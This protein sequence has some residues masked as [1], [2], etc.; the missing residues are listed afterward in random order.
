VTR[1]RRR[2]WLLAAAVASFVGVAGSLLLAPPVSAHAGLVSSVPAASS[3]L[4]EAP[5]S[6]VLDFDE[7]LEIDLAS[8]ELFD[9][10]AR[11]IPLGTVGG[12]DGDD[13]IVSA[14][15]PDL[16][17]GIFAVVWRV[18]SV[19]GHVV[20]GSFS[21]TV[22]RAD[23]N[24]GD[25]L[26]QLAT[27]SG[28]D[29]AVSRLAL[30]FRLVGFVGLVVFVGGGL[31][32][33][34]TARPPAATSTVLAGGWTALLVGS[35]GVFGTHA[36]A[37]TAGGAGDVFAPSAWSAVAGTDTGRAMLVRVSLV[38]ALGA[39]VWVG[40]TVER[41]STAWWR[42]LVGL[43]AVGV[44][45]T[46][47]AAGHAA[48]TSPRAL[49][50]LVDAVHLA[51]IAVWL[52][53]LALFTLG[54]RDWLRDDLYEPVVRRF[55]RMAGVAVPVVVVTGIAQTRELAGGFG[56][57][58]D[59][60]WGRGMLVKLSIVVVLVTVGGV[61]RW[62]LHHDGPAGLRRT[63]ALEAVLG[64]A[65]L[66]TVAFIVAEPP[67]PV[68]QGK[69]FS[70][71]LAQAG[72]IVDITVTPGK[73]GA[74]EIHLVIT[75]PGGN[76]RPVTNA[77]ARMALPERDVPITPVTM[78]AESANHYSGRITLPFGGD[79]KL[80]VLVEDRPGSTILFTTT[81]SI[82]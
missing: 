6:I 72:I 32:A 48:A 7:P 11:R 40:A 4:E 23:G 29:P 10:E 9:V 59:T 36:A 49:F 76:L 1:P 41:R 2:W 31:F 80:D 27:G 63:V 78:E 64:V 5:E 71:T 44:L 82:P 12:V 43:A 24:A 34:Q 13:S 73:V 52:G 75:P 66:A 53:G 18:T 30:M 60:A 26:D 55:S 67:R 57:I 14:S 46:Y 42:S 79:W 28:T 19:D 68:D 8:I 20:D 58:T 16:D 22:G 33:L 69:V 50:T 35:L 74:N 3:V 51:G 38:V 17:D 56:D 15:V 47:P 70:A 65:V 81:V 77:T 62:L 37:A 21:F 39:L 61:S 25:L 54:G 45:F